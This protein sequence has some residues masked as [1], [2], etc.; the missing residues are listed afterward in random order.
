MKQTILFCLIGLLLTGGIYLNRQQEAGRLRA[1]E[2]RLQADKFL[3]QQQATE[4][5]ELAKQLTGTTDVATFTEA[6]YSCARRTGIRDH[7]VITTRVNAEQQARGK[8]NR[9]KGATLSEQQLEV[10][11]TADFRR[12]AEYID[13]VQ[14]LGHHQRISKLTLTPGDKQLKATMV[15]NLYS[16]G[17]PYVR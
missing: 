12:I 1:E 16:L 4:I 15:I 14:K 9:S 7:E 8:R 5:A 3:L 6:L 11:L 13:Q 2:T 17:E 10:V